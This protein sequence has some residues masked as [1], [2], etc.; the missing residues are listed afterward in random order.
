MRTMPKKIDPTVK[1]RCV[2]QVPEQLPELPSLTA[3]AE[4]V[5]RRDASLHGS[6]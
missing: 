1:A 4:A 2:R 5:A 6:R 3:A